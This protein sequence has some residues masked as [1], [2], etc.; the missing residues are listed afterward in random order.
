TPDHFVT[1]VNGVYDALRLGGTYGQYWV[2][3]DNR[4]DDTWYGRPIDP[5]TYVDRFNVEPQSGYVGQVW[6]DHYDGI[7]RANA[8]LD[9]L[10]TA[11]FSS[12]LR[13]RLIGEAKF[14]RALLYFNLVRTYGDVPLVT[15]EI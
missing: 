13:D 12:T 6:D 11:E 4:S 5:S 14:L 2:L 3:T 7:A 1:A 10:E 8:V 15:K 9:R